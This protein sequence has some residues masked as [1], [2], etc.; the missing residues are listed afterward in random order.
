MNRRSEISPAFGWS[1]ATALLLA[2]LVAVASASPARAHELT[3]AQ[4]PNVAGDSAAHVRADAVNV[5]AGSRDRKMMKRIQR[6]ARAR[7]K[8]RLAL[9]LPANPVEVSDQGIRQRGLLQ[10]LGFDVPLTAPNLFDPSQGAKTS[11]A[12]TTSASGP[13]TSALEDQ[14]GVWGPILWPIYQVKPGDPDYS[15]PANQNPTS[16]GSGT[17]PNPPGDLTTNPNPRI[18]PV[19]EALMPDGKVL[20]WDW[21]ISGYFKDP[22]VQMSTRILL[23][24]PLHPSSPGQRLD[25]AGA[26][27]FCAGYSHLPNGDLFLAGGNANNAFHGLNDT[28]VYHWRSKTWEQGPDMSRLRWYPS[29]AS[30]Y[31][32]EAMI[33]GGDPPGGYGNPG[34]VN[35][36]NAFADRSVPEVYSAKYTDPASQQ[37]DSNGDQIR[38]LDNVRFGNDVS[39]PGGSDAVNPPSSRGYPFLVPSVDGRVL[40]AGY[41]NGTY[42]VD[43]TGAG[44]ST[45]FG[46]HDS[47]WRV[48][49]SFV[50]YNVGK[51]LLFGG[52]TTAK[53][54]P[55]CD[56]DNL[57]G[58]AT[59]QKT[60]DEENGATKTVKYIDLLNSNWGEDQQGLPGG[61]VGAYPGASSDM[62]FKRRFDYS[63]VLP[64][65]KVLITGGMSNTDPD[66]GDNAADDDNNN[67]LV[68]LPAAVK[69]AE[70]FDPTNESFTTLASAAVAREYHSTAM[71][72]PD[73]TVLTGGGGVCG[74]CTTQGNHYYNP[75]F[76]IFK[77]PYLFNTNGSLA[78]QPAITSSTQND[79]GTQVLPPADYAQP[80]DINYAP[81]FKNGQ[82]KNISTAALLKLGTPTHSTDTGQ[83]F[84]P[85]DFVE[86]ADNQVLHMKAPNNSYIAPPGFYMLFLVDDGGTPSISKMIQIG[87][88]LALHNVN[89]AVNVFQNPGFSG[90]AQYLGTGEFMQSKGN[91]ANVGDQAIS[92]MQVA[93]GYEAKVCA[94]SNGVTGCNTFGPG[95]FSTLAAGFDNSIRYIKVEADTGTGTTPIDPT[96]T[97]TPPTKPLIKLA[98]SLKLA[99]TF[100]LTAKCT[101]ECWADATVTYGKKKMKLKGLKFKASTTTKKLTFKLTKKQLKTLQAAKKKKQK[102]SLKVTLFD[103]V[104]QATSASTK[105]K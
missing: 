37:F 80:F 12:P 14:T 10:N 64:D 86:D 19:F 87:A 13:T 41:E 24:D 26:N 70:L 100:S 79:A 31:N 105:I 23:W 28:Y 61:G 101:T 71:L 46:E 90:V 5:S 21:L 11:N 18:V 16:T 50:D 95:N 82:S 17:T 85:L 56:A 35:G 39:G 42:L 67:N 1:V 3:N 103:S 45:N 52:G 93:P 69:A 73:A 44:G 94:S 104:D 20:Y 74:P 34:S 25:V 27:L 57:V 40:Y 38:Q 36:P 72:L 91:F 53:Y 75:N 2:V 6:I 7:M 102:L 30:L 48:N 60:S 43:T 99:S 32:G 33:L 54:G 92:S 62:N 68:N 76:E 47:H 81:G 8:K 89:S 29:V 4:D 55:T 97:P 58:S 59:C 88:N 83:R 98:K 65:G 84:I 9:G 22:T 66:N 51:V 63:T 49:G 15:L 77:P 78:T 96:P